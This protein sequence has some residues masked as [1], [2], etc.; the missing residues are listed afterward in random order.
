[1]DGKMKLAFEK[2]ELLKAMNTL[3]RAMN[4]EGAYYTWCY[5]IPD[6]ADDEELRE[7]A[8][9]EDDELY[10][11]ACHSFRRICEEYL[12]HGFFLGGFGQPKG[13]FGAKKDDIEEDEDDEE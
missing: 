4:D 12:K 8:F 2:F 1:M 9:D 11:D 13:L 6:G 3:V 10:R 5:V 7:I